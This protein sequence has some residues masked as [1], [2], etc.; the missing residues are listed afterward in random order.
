MASR[1]QNLENLGTPKKILHALAAT[2]LL[3]KAACFCKHATGRIFLIK[4]KEAIEKSEIPR[5]ERTL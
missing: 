1:R 4:N 2:V 3:C 5:G